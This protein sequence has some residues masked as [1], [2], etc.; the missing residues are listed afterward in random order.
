MMKEHTR[1]QLR[2]MNNQDAVRL[3]S[4]LNSD[5]TA[6]KYTLEDYEAR[7]C[8]SARSLLGVMYMGMEHTEDMFLVNET[9]D[10]K[11]PSAIDQFR[12]TGSFD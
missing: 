2:I 10:G 11:F 4:I 3:V 1:A 7:H 8:V 9:E 5:G 6:D 12:P